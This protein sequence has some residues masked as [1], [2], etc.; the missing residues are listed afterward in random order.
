MRNAAL[1]H[2]PHGYIYCLICYK[3]L[4][5]CFEII[6]LHLIAGYFY[7]IP[8]I[9]AIRI[10]TQVITLQFCFYTLN[11]HWASVEKEAK[12]VAVVVFRSTWMSLEDPWFWQTNKPNKCSGQMYI[13]T[14]WYALPT[15]FNLFF[16]DQEFSV[17]TLFIFMG[18]LRMCSLGTW[19]GD[20]WNTS[21]L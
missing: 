14:L 15:P 3:P 12:R 21:C 18:S 1:Y 9:G 20:H 19:P 5:Y 7:E 13:L 8:S 4:L 16:L 11:V 6:L 17:S 2:L 10:N